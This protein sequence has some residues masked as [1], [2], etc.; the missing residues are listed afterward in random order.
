MSDSDK[1]L[2]FYIN[3]QPIQLADFVKN[4][5][6]IDPIALHTFLDDATKESPI[7]LNVDGTLVPLKFACGAGG[8]GAGKT[9]TPRAYLEWLGTDVMRARLG[10]NVWL[11]SALSQVVAERC[12]KGVVITD[13][14]F[15]NELEYGASVLRAKG[16]AVR[17]WRVINP[18]EVPPTGPQHVSATAADAVPVDVTITNY[19]SHGLEALKVCVREALKE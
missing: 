3:D 5:A 2:V 19:K 13:A 16:F 18:H 7:H 17:T 14:R 15:P 11:D 10:D 4:R 1:T 9:L 12:N 6:R 8:A